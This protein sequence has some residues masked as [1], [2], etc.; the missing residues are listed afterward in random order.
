MRRDGAEAA[1][2]DEDLV[3]VGGGELLRCDGAAGVLVGVPELGAGG[4]GEFGMGVPGLDLGCEG[5]WRGEVL[6]CRLG[7]HRALGNYWEFC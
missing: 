3:G 7:D 2:L 1:L 5:E 6:R 4:G